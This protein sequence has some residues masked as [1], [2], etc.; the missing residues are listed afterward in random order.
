MSTVLVTGAS[1]FV[2]RH[3][4]RILHDNGFAI[5]AGVHDR[6][7]I[8]APS[9]AVGIEEVPL[10]LLSMPSLKEA[11]EGVE[12]VYHF[13]ALVDSSATR[14]QLARI[15]GQG[16][17]NV[18]SCAAECGVK[19]ALYCSSTAVYGLLA[20]SNGMITEDVRPRAIE[21]YGYSKLMGEEA[22]LEIAAQ[23]GVHTTII[24]PVA[25]FGP[26]EHTPFGRRFR[27]ALTSRLVVAGG[28][29]HR[30]FS[31]VHVED[32][33]E[34]AVHVMRK[35]TSSGQIFNIA[36]NEPIAYEDA[37]EAYLRVLKTAGKSYARVRLLALISAFL[38]RL[39]PAVVRTASR[40]GK[41]FMFKIWHPGFDLNYS[42]AKLLQTGF[43]FRWVNFED[44]L[45]SCVEQNEGRDPRI[46]EGTTSRQ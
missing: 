5:R 33:A 3:V 41:R 13:A 2:G 31:F 12:A 19:R 27:D 15:N 39:P 23:T 22:A 25:I 8:A 10:N 11:M 35:E 14:E 44:V 43:R 46:Q 42:S 24:R 40:I 16:T 6:H 20:S 28:F 7:G 17:R 45:L 32:V 9:P 29:Q 34:A 21:P 38:H 26:G 18:W 4:V 37:F 1:G 36:V 30:R